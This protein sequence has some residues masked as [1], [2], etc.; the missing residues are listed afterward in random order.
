M[1]RPSFSPTTRQS[2]MKSTEA[3]RSSASSAKVPMPGLHELLFVAFDDQVKPFQFVRRKPKVP[4]QCNRC[5]PVL[6]RAVAPVDV[7]VGW[8]AWLMAVPVKPVG[9]FPENGRHILCR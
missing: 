4:C 6:G 1:Q 3:T 5:Q 2:A 7:H 8:H 9:P